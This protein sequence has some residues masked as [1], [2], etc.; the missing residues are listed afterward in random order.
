MEKKEDKINFKAFKKG[1]ESCFE[2]ANKSNF[3]P[4]ELNEEFKSIMQCH[5]LYLEN[6]GKLTTCRKRSID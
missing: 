1:F 3:S 2:Q 6:F 5:N 4:T